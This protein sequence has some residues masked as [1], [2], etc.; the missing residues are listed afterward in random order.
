MKTED[1]DYFIVRARQER[2]AASRSRGQVHDRHEEMAALYEMR[3][4]YIDR[5]MAGDNPVP[6]PVPRIIIPA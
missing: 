2:E 6:A 3:I 5:G 1:R 4:L